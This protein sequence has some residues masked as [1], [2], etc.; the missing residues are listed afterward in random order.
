M[1][2][3]ELAILTPAERDEYRQL[4]ECFLT[5]TQQE[6]LARTRLALHNFPDKKELM[7]THLGNILRTAER[8]PLKKYGL[9]PIIY[10]SRF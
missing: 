2:T 10:W 6:T 9:D 8:R 1:K 4:N 3:K 7:P 5:P